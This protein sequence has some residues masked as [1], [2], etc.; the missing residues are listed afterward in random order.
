MPRVLGAAARAPALHFLVLGA[1]L[2]AWNAATAVSE[3]PAGRAPIVISA[4]RVAAIR[5][6]YAKTVA[7]PTK[8]ELAALVAREADE[9]M[10]YRE[11][12]VLGLDRGD[13]AV[14]W[15]I[16]EK[17]HFLYGDALGDP[18][19]AF[20]RGMEL[21]LARDDTVVR[22]T[23]VTKMRLLAKAASRHEEPEG[24]ALD[25]ALQTYMEAHAD[26]FRQAD[27][28]TISHVFLSAERRGPALDADARAL[29][30]R[31]RADGTTPDAAIADRLGDPFAS[32]TTFRATSPAGLAKIF[33]EPLA[34]SVVTLPLATWSDPIRSAYGLHLVWVRARDA[35]AL[36]P[37][38]TVRPRVLRAY[39]AER[40]AAYLERMMGEL[41][42][43]YVVRVED[44]DAG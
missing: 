42:A 4:A 39:R 23:L 17:M 30:A 43:A 10:L 14:K 19:E 3:P 7:P 36:P 11:A 34:A 16:I 38:A 37:L 35:A 21:G 24:E 29:A 27:R 9:E 41:R 2:A 1:L 33:G 32:G 20:R 25:R 5:E 26:D 13:G 44:A 28:L 40:R 12:L 6:D 18:E 22:N 15:R 31:L 8:Q